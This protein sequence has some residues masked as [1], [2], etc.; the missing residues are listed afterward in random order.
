MQM[1]ASGP[2]VQHAKGPSGRTREREREGE[3][4][5]IIAQRRRQRESTACMPAFACSCRHC[6]WALK[7]AEQQFVSL[8][9]GVAT[10]P[11]L[12]RQKDEIL[13]EQHVLGGG[14]GGEGG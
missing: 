14:G 3:S 5:R 2:R 1:H 12:W 4:A 9:A 8:P 6:M 7:G 11:F 10:F 13:G